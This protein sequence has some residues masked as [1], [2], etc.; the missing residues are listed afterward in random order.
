MLASRSLLTSGAMAVEIAEDKSEVCTVA[1]SL[2]CR[3][4]MADAWLVRVALMPA[5]ELDVV[6]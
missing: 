1:A 3:A 2:A 5:I 6:F 4:A